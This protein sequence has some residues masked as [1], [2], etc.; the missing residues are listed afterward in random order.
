[1]WMTMSGADNQPCDRL[2]LQSD[3]EA[4]IRENNGKAWLSF[5]S[6][7]PPSEYS[8]IHGH[9]RSTEGLP[10]LTTEDEQ[11]KLSDITNYSLVVNYNGECSTLS[12]K[13]V[14]PTITFTD[15]H[16]SKKAVECLD[17]SSGGLGVSCDS[18]GELRVWQTDTGEVRRQL[19]GHVGDVYTAKFFPSGIVVLSAGADTMI[20]VW[21]AETGECAATMTGH[22]AAVLDTAVVDRGRN[23]VSVSRDGSACLWDVGKQKTLMSLQDIGGQI[24]CCSIGV[25][26]NSIDLGAGNV[27]RSDREI[28]TEGKM[29]LVGLENGSLQGFGLRSREQVFCINCE[30]PVNSCCFVSETYAICGTQDS[31]LYVIDLRNTSTPVAKWKE[32]RGPIKSLLPHKGGCFIST[33]D[34][35]CFHVNHQWITTTEL[36][37]SDCDPI[38]RISSDNT[39]IYTSC[40]DG[41]IR[42]YSL[43]YI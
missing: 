23:I 5:K 34:G 36:T 9:G 18:K 30:S 42:C 21:S 16:S 12:R 20:K 24:N 4:A 33:N 10:Y 35:S 1:V 3:W 17:T 6:S 28:N 2:I 38:Y 26:E 7:V 13:F 27:D 31:S 15:V 37:G 11:F 29:L 41:N 40:R 19:K 14:A 22:K 8:A 32:S 39:N 43:N 25:T